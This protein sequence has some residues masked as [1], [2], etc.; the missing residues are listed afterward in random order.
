MREIVSHV[1]TIARP[2]KSGGIALSGQVVVAP[3]KVG[4]R[5]RLG[6]WRELARHWQVSEMDAAADVRDLLAKLGTS[7]S[8]AV[9]AAAA[10]TAL[11]EAVW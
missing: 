3:S 11:R 2:A 8:A 7:P 4:W 1:N 5:S 6:S 9:A 10:G